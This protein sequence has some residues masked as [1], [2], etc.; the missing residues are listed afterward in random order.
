MVKRLEFVQNVLKLPQKKTPNIIWSIEKQAS[1]THCL[2]F[3]FSKNLQYL[4]SFLKTRISELIYIKIIPIN[5]ETISYPFSLLKSDFRYLKSDFFVL[6]P[7]SNNISVPDQSFN[8]L[9]PNIE[10]LLPAKIKININSDQLERFNNFNINPTGI[11][12]FN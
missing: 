1:S 6:N 11:I 10:I 7:Y 4:F 2:F 9:I 5:S 8:S 12:S 3:C